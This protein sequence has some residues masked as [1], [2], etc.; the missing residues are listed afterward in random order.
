[1]SVTAVNFLVQT[2]IPYKLNKPLD[3][4]IK[5]YDVLG[6]EVKSFSVGRQTA[7]VHNIIW[8]GKDNLG[9]RT[10]AGIYFYQLRASN[11]TQVKKMIYGLRQI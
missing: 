3:A 6:R 11:E 8:D 2:T 4:S 5:I 1:M 7:G 9:R 10:A